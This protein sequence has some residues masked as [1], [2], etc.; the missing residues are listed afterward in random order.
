[1]ILFLTGVFPM[2]SDPR[3]FSDCIFSF[4]SGR[5][6]NVDL[7]ETEKNLLHPSGK[8]QSAE[9]IE[10]TQH[11]VDNL[12]IRELQFSIRKWISFI[13]VIIER[14]LVFST[15]KPFSG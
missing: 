10:I 9:K 6:A 3:A 1:M 13:I 15:I 8:K 14:T 4:R 5:H 2:V 7:V 12:H 11:V